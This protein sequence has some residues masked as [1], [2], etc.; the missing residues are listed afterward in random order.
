[1]KHSIERGTNVRL[2]LSLEEALKLSAD[3]SNAVLAIHKYQFQ[4]QHLIRPL[5]IAENK[6]FRSRVDF[7]GTLTI[8]VNNEVVE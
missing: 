1:M 4:G 7:A 3:L 5:I 8:S 6:T 2:E